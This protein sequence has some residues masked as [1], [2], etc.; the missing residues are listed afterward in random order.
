M[1]YDHTNVHIDD[2]YREKKNREIEI[3]IFAIFCFKKFSKSFSLQIFL[4]TEDLKKIREIDSSVEIFWQF[5][6]NFFLC[7]KF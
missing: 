6:D 3:K 5:F 7:V 1:T 2:F 4:G